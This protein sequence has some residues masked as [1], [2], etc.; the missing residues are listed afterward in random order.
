MNAQ[1]LIDTAR[2]LVAGDKRL[3]AMDEGI[4][5]CNLPG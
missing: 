3:Q 2:A 5:R 1:G 4:P